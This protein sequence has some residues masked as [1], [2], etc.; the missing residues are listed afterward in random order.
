MA[1]KKAG[2]TVYNGRDS[3][4][5]RLGIKLFGGEATLAGG[6]IVRQ[7]GN[8]YFAGKNVGQGK[9]FTLFALVAGTVSFQE[10]KRK[11]FD[12]RTRLVTYVNIDPVAA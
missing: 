4:A 2:G 1:T 11:R 6:I 10:K 7:K 5:K 12:G 8:T 9:D 3:Q